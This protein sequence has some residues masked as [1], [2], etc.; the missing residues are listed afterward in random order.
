MPR[1]KASM[2]MSAVEAPLAA[3]VLN[4][5]LLAAALI[6]TCRG[7][8]DL[9]VR[10]LGRPLTARKH[11]C[12]R[13]ILSASSSCGGWLVLWQARGSHPGS[14]RKLPCLRNLDGH[15]QGIR[16]ATGRARL[17]HLASMHVLIHACTRSLSGLHRAGFNQC[18][19]RR[20]PCKSSSRRART[21]ATRCRSTGAVS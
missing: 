15:V 2:W 8:S 19:G 17:R 5:L 13:L 14:T 20:G 12:A 9:S 3:V 1:D 10:L 21:T 18:G 7:L 16:A 11:M 4:G 6:G